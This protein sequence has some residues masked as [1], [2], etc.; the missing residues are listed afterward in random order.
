L[1]AKMMQGTVST[2]DSKRCLMICIHS[3]SARRRRSSLSLRASAAS[4]RTR[5]WSMAR[6]AK[7]S[8]SAPGE[9]PPG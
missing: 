4:D 7:S 9:K 3:T 1:Q 5:T 6:R 2:I 8:S